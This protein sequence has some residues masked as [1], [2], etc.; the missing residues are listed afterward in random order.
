MVFDHR[1]YLLV[2]Y[3]TSDNILLTF[4]IILVLIASYFYSI[5]HKQRKRLR[6][7]SHGSHSGSGSTGIWILVWLLLK[8]LNNKS[9]WDYLTASIASTGTIVGKMKFI[10]FHVVFANLSQCL[11]GNQCHGDQQTS[12]PQLCD[13]TFLS[14]YKQLGS[15]VR[16]G[17]W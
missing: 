17:Y 8:L 16:C 5:I 11:Y 6:W 1:N 15:L 14:S 9:M 7:S 13:V 10:K 2:M 12:C 3:F 4:F